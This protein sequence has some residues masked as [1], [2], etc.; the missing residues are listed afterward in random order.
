MEIDKLVKASA[1]TNL[2][3]VLGFALYGHLV[4]FS[5]TLCYKEGDFDARK[6]APILN[7]SFLCMEGPLRAW[8]PPFLMP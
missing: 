1:P 6:G 5:G 4:P 2:K 8:K 3:A 7:R